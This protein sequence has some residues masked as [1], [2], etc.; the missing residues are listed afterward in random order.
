MVFDQHEPDAKTESTRKLCFL[1]P[2]M[3]S[4]SPITTADG[5]RMRWLYE[6]FCKPSYAL[7]EV[8]GA[9]HGVGQIFVISGSIARIGMSSLTLKSSCGLTIRCSRQ[10]ETVSRRNCQQ[11]AFQLSRHPIGR[12]RRT[13]KQRLPLAQNAAVQ[14][15]GGI[16]C[17]SGQDKS[18]PGLYLYE[19]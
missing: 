17:Q 16:F 8:L 4:R 5:Q 2:R 7:E 10:Q 18:S 19:L 3:A 6:L 14:E 15:R 11:L 12:A 9:L 13:W 1:G